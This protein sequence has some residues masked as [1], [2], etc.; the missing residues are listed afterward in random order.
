MNNIEITIG[1]YRYNKRELAQILRRKMLSK[2]TI[3][4]KKY[5]RKNHKIEY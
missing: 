1:V 2:S 3:N 4:K 5:N